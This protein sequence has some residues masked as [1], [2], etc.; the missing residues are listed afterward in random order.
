ME[1]APPGREP[2]YREIDEQIS[3]NI[4]KEALHNKRRL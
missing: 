4:V 2:D 3:E 1:L